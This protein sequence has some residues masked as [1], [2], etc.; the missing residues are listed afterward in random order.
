MVLKYFSFV[1]ILFL[2]ALLAC[3]RI[4]EWER[5]YKP[6]QGVEA[7]YELDQ[8]GNW[9][10]T[11][12]GRQTQYRLGEETE[13][14]GR[15]I[16]TYLD[17]F[18][19][20]G[21]SNVEATD[22]KTLLGSAF[23]WD[24]SGHLLSLYH[25]VEQIRDLECS[26]GHSGWLS[27]EVVGSDAPLNLSLLKVEIPKTEGSLSSRNRWVGR[28]DRPKLD[29]DIRILS[30]AYPG[31]IDQLRVDLQVRRPNLNTGIDNGLILFMPPAPQLMRGGVLVDESMRFV[32]ILFKQRSAAWGSAID[33]KMLKELVRSIQQ[34][35]RVE[36]PFLGLRVR[37]MQG[38][39][40]VVQEVE[41]GGPAYQSGLRVNDIIE[42]W[43][44]KSLDEF[45]SWPRL[46]PDLLGESVPIVYSREGRQVESQIKIGSRE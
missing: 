42:S 35:G 7:R 27:A 6:T 37:Y 18:R 10:W 14:L 29:E 28:Q 1:L 8:F 39:G 3:E 38:R 13:L 19:T 21:L 26:N 32:G 45:E 44:G 40:F 31:V 24:S 22:A 2:P 11:C 46:N 36:R 33:Y 20:A 15:E 12:R 9:L 16:E 30:S 25:W 41:V 5:N 23:L 43:G 34:N 17:R 4:P